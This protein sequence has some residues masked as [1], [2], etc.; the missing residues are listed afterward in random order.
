MKASKIYA[1][2]GIKVKSLSPETGRKRGRP[3]KELS[4]A[5]KL[6][7]RA[8]KAW[9]TRRSNAVAK[10]T[11]NVSVKFKNYYGENKE[12]ARKIMIDAICATPRYCGTK[13][14]RILTLPA[15]KAIIERRL[16]EISSRFTFSAVEYDKNV[17][18]ELHKTIYENNMGGAMDVHCGKISDIIYRANKDEFSHLILD[19]CGEIDT[20]YDEIDYALMHKIVQVNG[21]VSITVAKRTHPSNKKTGIVARMNKMYPLRPDA[22]GEV[23]WALIQIFEEYQKRGLYSFET[24]KNYSDS[25]RG[26]NMALIVLRRI[27]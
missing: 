21:T 16:L 19:Y 13:I 26:A 9:A 10:E 5:E 22:I 1:K 11:E 14:D 3:C 25:T 2:S 4:R 17:A 12:V 27:K 20:F 8:K 6:T 7:L 24:L 18:N 23:E 15:A